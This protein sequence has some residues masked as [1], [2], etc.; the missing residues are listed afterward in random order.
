[1]DYKNKDFA[2]IFPARID[3]KHKTCVH[4][5][6]SEVCPGV[7]GVYLKRLLKERGLK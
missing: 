6:V 5:F 1:M 7:V 3:I 2:D 4:N